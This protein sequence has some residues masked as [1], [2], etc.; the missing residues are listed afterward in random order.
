MR[1]VLVVEPQRRGLAVSGLQE[2]HHPAA[3]VLLRRGA[4][5]ERGDAA[6][7]HRGL[8]VR[9]RARLRDRK[10]RRV[11]ER[12]DALVPLD[13]QRVLVGGEPSARR[14]R[15]RSRSRPAAPLCGGTRTS[16]SYSAFSPSSDSTT[17]ALASTASTLKNVVSPIPRSSMIRLDQLRGALDRERPVQR[18]EQLD[19]ALVAEPLLR[20]YSSTMNVNSTGAGG[21]L[22]GMPATPTFSR[23]P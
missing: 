17:P 13:V 9:R 14:R 4:M 16:R 6:R 20:R 21:H 22:Y 7:D 10:V 18:R 19:L 1:R 15:G 5:H 8:E 2:A 11:A 23:P 3:V 12:E